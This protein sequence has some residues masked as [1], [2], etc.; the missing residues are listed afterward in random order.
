MARICSPSPPVLRGRGVGVRGLQCAP[1]SPSPPLSTGG[2]GRLALPNLYAM[3]C[4]DCKELLQQ[5]LDGETVAEPGLAA[6]LAACEECRALRAASQRLQ[7]GVRLL[8][9]PL[10]PTELAS[11]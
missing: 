3:T 8:P 5:G 6:H 7:A 11:R 10:P 1:P 2:K 4:H 9:R